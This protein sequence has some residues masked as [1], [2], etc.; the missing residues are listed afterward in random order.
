M[1][2]LKVSTQRFSVII[3]QYKDSHNEGFSIISFNGFNAEY[4]L[5]STE[6]VINDAY[7]LYI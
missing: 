2:C 1:I 7:I 6:K 4:I 5:Y 3:Q